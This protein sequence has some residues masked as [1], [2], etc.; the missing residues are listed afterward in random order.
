M[1]ELNTCNPNNF[2][3]GLLFVHG[4]ITSSDAAF[5]DDVTKNPTLFGIGFVCTN[6][7]YCWTAKELFG[8]LWQG[9]L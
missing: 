8:V 9:T 1:F 5:Q 6:V 7:R 4:A 2:F 3:S